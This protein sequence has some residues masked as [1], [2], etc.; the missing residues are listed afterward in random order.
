MRATIY[1]IWLDECTPLV[2]ID[3]GRKA[4]DPVKPIWGRLSDKS[5]RMTKRE[6]H[7]W[8]AKLGGNAIAT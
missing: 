7:D 4:S 1:E 3:F 6:A 8:A 2:G 5:L